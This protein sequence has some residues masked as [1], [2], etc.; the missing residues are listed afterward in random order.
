MT[1]RTLADVDLHR[2]CRRASRRRQSLLKR[3]RYR[4]A[5]PPEAYDGNT[6]PAPIEMPPP[7]IL[8]SG[9]LPYTCGSESRAP[10]YNAAFVL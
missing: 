9:P 2:N 6:I 10:C 4:R 8:D 7:L 5:F 3:R 1:I